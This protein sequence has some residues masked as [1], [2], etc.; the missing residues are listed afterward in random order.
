MNNMKK[1]TVKEGHDPLSIAKPKR[2]KIT[3]SG[4]SSIEVNASPDNYKQAKE[5]S[6]EG[7]IEIQNH[8]EVNNE[9]IEN[10]KSPERNVSK[11]ESQKSVNH[12]KNNDY[13]TQKVEGIKNRNRIPSDIIPFEDI[14]LPQD[15]LIDTEKAYF[16]KEHPNLL[17]DIYLSDFQ[18]FFQLKNFKVGT[19]KQREK[20]QSLN[21]LFR[22]YLFT[23][24]K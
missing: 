22:A 13:I 8:S 23:I 16:H 11:A 2:T 3:A 12:V 17:G 19:K 24:S 1:S 5:E 15:T 7:K 9:N 20:S 4:N 14:L 21:K 6:S 10:E 18:L